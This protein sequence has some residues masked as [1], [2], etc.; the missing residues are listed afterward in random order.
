MIPRLRR[1]TTALLL[2]ALVTTLAGAAP[3]QLPIATTTRL[4]VVALGDS[5][6]S[7]TACRCAAFPAMYGVLLHDHT[8][9]V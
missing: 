1:F 2:A 4:H 6:T 3:Q 5:V 7:G 8:T 9:Q